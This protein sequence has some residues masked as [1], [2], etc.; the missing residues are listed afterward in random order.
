MEVDAV[1]F[2]TRWNS[3]DCVAS[4]SRKLRLES[5]EK[6]AT[7]TPT[8]SPIK[9]VVWN[10]GELDHEQ[11]VREVAF[12]TAQ[13]S[14]MTLSEDS[15]KPRPVRKL[16]AETDSVNEIAVKATAQEVSEVALRAKCS[17]DSPIKDLAFQAVLLTPIKLGK[18]SP[19]P[20]SPSKKLRSPDDQVKSRAAR[21]LFAE[22][23]AVK[24]VALKVTAQEVSEVALRAK[25]PP[26]SPIKE[27]AFRVAPQEVFDVQ[28]RAK[29]PPDSPV[30]ELAFKVAS[31]EVFDLQLRTK[32]PPDSSIK[33]LAFQTALLS[34][35]K[36]G[37]DSFEPCSPSK[38]IRTPDRIKLREGEVDLIGVKSRLHR[39]KEKVDS[40]GAKVLAEP[41]EMPIN[42]L[43]LRVRAQP[44]P[45]GTLPFPFLLALF[46]LFNAIGH[47]F[48]RNERKCRDS[49][50]IALAYNGL[51]SLV[52]PLKALA[53]NELEEYAQMLAAMRKEGDLSTRIMN[54][55]EPVKNYGIAVR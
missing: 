26:D 14:P 50:D 17:P 39:Q 35:K 37:K 25:C 2:Q 33:E 38:K 7:K 15:P 51:A 40:L 31:Q 44:L 49:H 48:F 9:R 46:I 41:K 54:Y 18:D 23:D 29:C 11:F 22:E 4:P 13:L 45:Q 52:N 34:P 5:P 21:K 47:Y 24:E 27:V 32:C 36:L 12:E 53:P 10:E 20:C 1:R 19:E 42:S 30:K 6:Q 43:Q 55:F 8:A 28:L 16:F 3:E